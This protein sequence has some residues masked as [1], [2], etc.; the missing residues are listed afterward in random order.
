MCMPLLV[1]S[2]IKNAALPMFTLLNNTALPC[3]THRCS[4]PEFKH[5]ASLFL[6]SDTCMKSPSKS[7]FPDQ[8]CASKRDSSEKDDISFPSE[9]E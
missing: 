4:C 5:L 3:S 8:L 6:Q 7:V 1:C 2:A 9:S